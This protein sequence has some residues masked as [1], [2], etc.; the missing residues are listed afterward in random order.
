MTFWNGAS[1]HV[2]S[3]RSAKMIDVIG[4][5]KICKTHSAIQRISLWKKKWHYFLN[6]FIDINWIPEVL[7]QYRLYLGI[8]WNSFLPSVVTD[9]EDGTWTETW[10]LLGHVFQGFSKC[11]RFLPFYNHGT[12]F[13]FVPTTWCISVTPFSLFLF[14]SSIPSFW[15]PATPFAPKAPRGTAIHVFLVKVLED[16]PPVAVDW[17]IC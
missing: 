8:V 11:I 3:K 4:K 12:G 13:E 9:G 6:R 2:F 5:P 14:R 10:K 15:W 1:K 7:L 16:F 17:R